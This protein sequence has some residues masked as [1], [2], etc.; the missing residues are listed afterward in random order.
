MRILGAPA[1]DLA[2]EHGLVQIAQQRGGLRH[3]IEACGKNVYA[4]QHLG[5][6]WTRP[7]R[8]SRRWWLVQKRQ[9][10]LV[11]RVAV[12]PLPASARTILQPAEA[13]LGKA[14]ANCSRCAA[15][16]R[17][18]RRSSACSGPGPPEALFAPASHHT[19]PWWRRASSTSR[20]FGFSRTFRASGI[21]RS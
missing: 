5:Q 10:A 16:H 6:K 2:H 21:S 20:I 13:V 12:N 4:D 7:P 8:K 3:E 11:R 19:A 1:G 18:P 14:P 9:N 17:L 15:E